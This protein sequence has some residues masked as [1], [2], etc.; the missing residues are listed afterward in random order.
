MYQHTVVM[1]GLQ[2]TATVFQNG[3]AS[4]PPFGVNL[5]IREIATFSV[6]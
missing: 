4:D 3:V 5:H 1:G 6:T 2:L